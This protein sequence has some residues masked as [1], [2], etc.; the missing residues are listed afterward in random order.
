MAKTE[1]LTNHTIEDIIYLAGYI[2]GD[3]CFYCGQVNQGKRQQFHIKLIVTSCDDISTNWI[4]NTFGGNEEIQSRPA[5]NRPYDRIVYYW[6][7]TGDLLDYLLPKL[8]PY[9]KLK[10]RRCQIMMELRETFKNWGKEVPEEIKE[11][12]LQ[13]IKEMHSKNS[14]FHNHPLKQ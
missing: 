4:R 1:V 6:V 14:R 8:E 10:K 9:L 2:D 11:K 7:A 3:G 5:K 12:R 13:L